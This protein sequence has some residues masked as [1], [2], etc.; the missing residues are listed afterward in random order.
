MIYH[1]PS[2]DRPAARDSA[3][4]QATKNAADA[5]LPIFV[6]RPGEHRASGRSIRLGWVTDWDDNAK[7][8]LILFGEQA[9]VSA[10]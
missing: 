3:E 7:P 1:Y 10:S 9:R 2:T 4:V 8:F 5:N 6:I